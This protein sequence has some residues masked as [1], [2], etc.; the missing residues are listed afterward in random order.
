MNIG[1]IGYG[2]VGKA[3]IRLLQDKNLEVNL[4]FILKSNGGIIGENPLSLEEVIE[5]EY[6]LENH[7]CWKNK[8]NFYDVVDSDIDLLVDVTPTNKDTGE[9]TLSY[10]K[11]ALSKG[12]N[13]VTANKGPVLIDYSGMKEI[14]EKNGVFLGLGCTTGGALPTLSTGEVGC[15][16]AEIQSIEGILNGTTNF[17]LKEMEDN[18]VTYEEALKKAQNLGIAEREPSLDVEGYDTAIKMVIITNALMSSNIKLTDVEVEGITSLSLDKIR[19]IKAEGKKIKL[20][21]RTYIEDE[22]IKI[23]VSPEAIG[24]NHNLY[25]VEG[26]NKGIS[27]KT[28]TLGDITVIGG[29]SST[30]N[31]AA[32]I[33]RDIVNLY[34]NK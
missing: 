7:R 24:K 19:E 3:F 32:A 31:A 21:G 30:K 8:I 2:G 28:D 9:P 20:L 25:G 33:L 27:Y 6:E 18:D 26:S 22:I 15:A 14:A 34:K 29:A 5:S 11:L 1:V 17:I 4:I 10:I 16:G 23:K 12:I 13:V